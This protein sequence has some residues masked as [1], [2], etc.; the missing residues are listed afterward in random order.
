MKNN[1]LLIVAVWPISVITYSVVLHWVIVMLNVI[2]LSVIVLSV[3]MP[4]VPCY[5][6]LCW[7]SLC[8]LSVCWVC[9]C[10]DCHYA[11]S[12]RVDCC[13]TT[14]RTLILLSVSV[15]WQYNNFPVIFKFFLPFQA[16]KIFNQIFSPK[17]TRQ[18][19]SVSIW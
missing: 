16:H 14:K 12:H 15:L 7:L 6:P 17:L 5:V 8:W 13:S 2:V 18:K 11:E 19:F 1:T 4:S 10:A 9:R 3:L